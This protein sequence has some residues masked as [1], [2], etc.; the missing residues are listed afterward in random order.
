MLPAFIWISSPSAHPDLAFALCFL[1]T[2]LCFKAPSLLVGVVFPG[3]FPP[4]THSVTEPEQFVF[5]PI[6]RQRVAICRECA[7][8]RHST[9]KHRPVPRNTT[10]IWENNKFIGGKWIVAQEEV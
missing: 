8:C 2:S 3:A 7:D 10:Q 4:K 1:G 9:L 5:A 6:Q